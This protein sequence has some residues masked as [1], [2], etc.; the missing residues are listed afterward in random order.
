VERGPYGTVTGI[1]LLDHTFN[2]LAEASLVE[3]ET[4]DVFA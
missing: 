3:V 1:E 2:L 4:K